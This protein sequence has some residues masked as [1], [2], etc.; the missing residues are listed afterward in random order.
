MIQHLGLFIEASVCFKRS[1]GSLTA[2]ERSL[3]DSCFWQFLITPRRNC[4]RVCSVIPNCTNLGH[5]DAEL[6]DG[7]QGGGGKQPG[8]VRDCSLPT[9]LSSASVRNNYKHFCLQ[10]WAHDTSYKLVLSPTRQTSSQR[11]YLKPT[12]LF[13]RRFHTG[14]LVWIWITTTSVKSLTSRVDL[15][16]TVSDQK[17]KTKLSKS[18]RKPQIQC[19]REIRNCSLS[20]KQK[21]KVTVH[22]LTSSYN[23][24]VA[25]VLSSV[26]TSETSFIPMLTA[27]WCMKPNK[28]ELPYAAIISQWKTTRI[29]QGGTF[30]CT[31]LIHSSLIHQHTLN[32]KITSLNML[33]LFAWFFSFGSLALHRFKNIYPMIYCRLLLNES[34]W[35]KGIFMVPSATCDVLAEHYV[36]LAS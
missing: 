7:D 3:C 2:S 16:V 25:C 8:G 5:R 33:F 18:T 26:H 34:F 14:R 6:L 29:F 4:L 30:S 11:V 13:P 28:D 27:Q 35:G 22:R 12:E 20:L 23:K 19:S 32:V 21:N 31:L 36:K 10:T 1:A 9:Q 17:S 24:N 15:K